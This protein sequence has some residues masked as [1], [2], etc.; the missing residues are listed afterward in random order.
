[1]PAKATAETFELYRTYQIAVHKDPP[2]KVH[3]MGYRRFLCDSPLTVG[4]DINV[5]NSR[6][7]PS[8]TTQ[9]RIRQTCHRNTD[10]TTFVSFAQG[11][12]DDGKLVGISVIDILPLCVSSVYFIWDSDY[13]WASL[14]KLS[15]LREL[16]LA[17]DMRRAGAEKMGWVY[18]G[19]LARFPLLQL[20]IGYWIPG[21]GKMMYKSEYSPSYL[22]DPVGA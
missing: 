14:G 17:R 3:M 12:A 7:R 10:R 16:A 8:F 2:E 15:A 18:M 19:Q 22:L 1:V 21:C 11:R 5:V 4:Y 13:A 6:N 9:T 20:T